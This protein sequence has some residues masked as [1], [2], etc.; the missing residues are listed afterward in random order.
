MM[1][2]YEARIKRVNDEIQRHVGHIARLES[3]RAEYYVARRNEVFQE[4]G[5]W[6]GMKL[7]INTAFFEEKRGIVEIDNICYPGLS[8]K[9]I[10]YRLDGNFGI[11]FDTW[12]NTVTLETLHSMRRDYVSGRK[13]GERIEE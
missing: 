9:L 13:L 10:D 2:D 6:V 5:F 4:N 12:E 3:E 1:I 7:V 8:A 11:E